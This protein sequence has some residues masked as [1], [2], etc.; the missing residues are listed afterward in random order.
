[1]WPPALKAAVAALAPAR[2]SGLPAAVPFGAVFSCFMACCMLG[3]SAFSMAAKAGLAAE[4]IAV[5]MLGLAVCS[6]G[7]ATT[8]A[9]RA[10]LLP[11]SACLFLFESCV[12]I[13]FPTIGTLR[14]R[15]LPDAHRGAIMNLFGIPLNLIVVV[16]FLSIAKLGTVGALKCSTAALGMLRAVPVH[17]RRRGVW[18][19]TVRGVW[20][21]IVTRHTHWTL[22]ACHTARPIGAANPARPRLR[23]VLVACALAA[24]LALRRENRRQQAAPPKAV[25]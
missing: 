13:Y 4:D 8:A 21:C 20:L 16:V 6:M 9:S 18:L 2:A 11:L 5:S 1:M 22:N 7:L 12:G 10:A 14:S 19:C 25:A 17:K 23:A 3:S 15:L 24:A